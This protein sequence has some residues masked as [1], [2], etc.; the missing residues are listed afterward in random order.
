MGTDHD[1]ISSTA[2]AERGLLES[3]DAVVNR[4]FG[5]GLAL[6]GILSLERVDAEVAERLREAIGSLDA[7]VVELRTAALAEVVAGNAARP[8]RRDPGTASARRRLSGVSIDD[9]VF[10]YAVGRFDF[11]R[12]ADHSLWA[13]ESDGLLLSVRSGA[14]LA[15]RDGNLF[16]DLASN[17]PLYFEEA[18]AGSLPA[19]VAGA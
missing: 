11:Y 13:H 19:A 18:P 7:A 17:A 6:A 10:A 4:I 8:A 5:A 14:P 16:Y 1:L 3:H 15:R 9:D 2:A 12:A